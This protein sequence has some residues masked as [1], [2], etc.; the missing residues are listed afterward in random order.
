M[1][2]KCACLWEVKG[3]RGEGPLQDEKIERWRER[4]AATAAAAWAETIRVELGEKMFNLLS[5]VEFPVW[6]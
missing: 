5:D 2:F 6:G 4:V 1:G 3:Q